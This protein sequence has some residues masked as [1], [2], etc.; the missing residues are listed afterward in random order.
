MQH[1]SN[2]CNP[3]G[4]LK[5]VNFKRFLISIASHKIY[6]LIK[7]VYLPLDKTNMKLEF[8]REGK[9]GPIFPASQKTF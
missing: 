8:E 1:S 3:T 4:I 2:A 6:V 9:L 5:N 7:N